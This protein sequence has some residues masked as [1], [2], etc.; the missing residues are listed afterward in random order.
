MIFCIEMQNCRMVLFVGARNSLVPLKTACF[1]AKI[2]STKIIWLE[3]FDWLG[4]AY[5]LK[6]YFLP[7]YL[8]L[9]ISMVQQSINNFKIF[10]RNG[11][12]F[13]GAEESNSLH[14]DLVLVT[15]RHTFVCQKVYPVF[16]AVIT[17]QRFRIVLVGCL[18]LRSVHS[19]F[20]LCGAISLRRKNIHNYILSKFQY[21]CSAFELIVKPELEFHSDWHLVYAYYF[22]AVFWSSPS[23][24]RSQICCLGEA[25][26]VENSREKEW[27]LIMT[28]NLRI[29]KQRLF[30]TLYNIFFAWELRNALWF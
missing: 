18:P 10:Q 4:K 21:H 28:A 6:W 15:G 7:S 27:V 23:G 30:Y 29:W 26:F 12:T 11:F 5:L 17:V 9:Q 16:A 3:W 22:F 2:L 19:Y 8:F 20:E 1:W 24:I 14:L 13:Y 25:L